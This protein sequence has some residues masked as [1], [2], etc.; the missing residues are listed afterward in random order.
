MLDGQQ[1]MK[2]G[3]GRQELLS[4]GLEGRGVE[5][6]GLV[7]GAALVVLGM[8][9]AVRAREQVEERHKLAEPGRASGED[10]VVQED[11]HGV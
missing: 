2:K 5:E 8:L 1:K 7:E 10:L 3:S 11:V 6:E 4:G 9:P